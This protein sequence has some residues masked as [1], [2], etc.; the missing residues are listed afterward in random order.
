MHMVISEQFRSNAYTH[1][2]ILLFKQKKLLQANCW[3]RGVLTTGVVQQ[4]LSNHRNHLFHN[5]NL[6]QNKMFKIKLVILYLNQHCRNPALLMMVIKFPQDISVHKVV[7][8]RYT[9]C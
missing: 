4:L 7:T 1:S 8:A 3:K 2:F 6:D 5:T 9:N